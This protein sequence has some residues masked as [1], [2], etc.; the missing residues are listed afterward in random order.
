MT[1]SISS[2]LVYQISFHNHILLDYNNCQSSENNGVFQKEGENNLT[3]SISSYDKFAFL[4][5]QLDSFTQFARFVIY[6]NTLFKVNFKY[7]FFS[8]LLLGW[9]QVG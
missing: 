8:C 7:H 4:T 2:A 3:F 1:L 6:E 9:F 5:K